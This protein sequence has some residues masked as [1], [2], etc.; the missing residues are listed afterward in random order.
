[1]AKAGFTPKQSRFIAAYDGN[2]TKA[3]KIA[4]YT[5][6]DKTLSVTASH[7]LANARI[8]AAIQSRS[9]Q[10]RNEK[11]SIATREDRQAFW[12]STMND[13]AVHMPDRLRA[14]ELL[15]K[16]EIDFVE[17]SISDSR[18]VLVIDPYAKP[19][20]PSK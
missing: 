17:K 19:P 3:A 4:G 5:G 15:G 16:S 13:V 1:M 9:P 12:S 7:L 2:G 14:S 6:N 11:K 10:A 8:V 20:E 18:V